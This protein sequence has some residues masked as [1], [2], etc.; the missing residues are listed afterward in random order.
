MLK[1]LMNKYHRDASGSALLN[2]LPMEIAKQVAEETT[3]S[4]AAAEAFVPFEEIIGTVHYS[5]FLEPLKEMPKPT[6]A[7][8]MNSLPSGHAEPLAEIFNTPSTPTTDLSPAVRSFLLSHLYEKIEGIGEVIPEAYLAPEPLQPLLALNRPMLLELFDLLGLYDLAVN[9]KKIVNKEKL[10]Q[11][12][13]CLSP[14][15]R[16]FLNL[17][18]SHPARLQISEL[19]LTSWKG[20]GNKLNKILHRRGIIRV[21]KALSGSSQDFLWH[22]VHRLDT[23]RGDIIK[24]YYSE[25]AMPISSVLTEQVLYIINVLTRKSQ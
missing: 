17:L 25:E 18:V 6:R 3:R 12:N 21:A 13:S 4:D 20:D 2:T 23:G 9:V 5:W 11:I 15:R 24:R 7:I 10:E 1:V 14:L 8:L 19:D 22:V 16:K